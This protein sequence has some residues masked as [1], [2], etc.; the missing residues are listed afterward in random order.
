MINMRKGI[1]RK[2]LLLFVILSTLVFTSVFLEPLQI[3]AQANLVE[4]N[5]QYLIYSGNYFNMVIPKDEGPTAVFDIHGFGKLNFELNYLSEYLSTSAF[6]HSVNNLYGLGYSLNDI[7]W[8]SVGSAETSKT[9]V[10]FTRS[11]LESNAT[12]QAS[13]NIFNQPINISGFEIPALAQA[14]VEFRIKD[15]E[16]TSEAKGIALNLITFQDDSDDYT[17]FGPYLDIPTLTY[18]VKI[19]SSSGSEFF[20]KFKP[21][22][23]IITTTG[24]SEEQDSMFFANYNVAAFDSEPVDFWIST[25]KRSNIK[26]IIFSF[27]CYYVIAPTSN[28][29][30]E[31]VVSFALSFI[32]IT[33]I[34]NII[35]MKRRKE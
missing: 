31:P 3:Q 8:S 33:I 2:S 17:R 4:E 9:Y 10:N 18:V 14:Y 7:E 27:L 20:I 34:A 35:K 25:P 16:F 15:W 29:A 12:L 19:I 6:M 22:I 28:T 1:I 5:E 24:E 21:N 11:Y 30:I 13:Y 26:E 32:T 23:T